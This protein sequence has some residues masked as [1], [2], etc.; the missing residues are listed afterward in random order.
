MSYEVR[1]QVIS[2]ILDNRNRNIGIVMHNSPD[3]DCIGSAVALENCLLK[4]NK[5]VDLIIQNR[6]PIEYSK[7][8]GENRVN[9]IFIPQN[10]YYD[11][12]FLV[13]CADPE[14]TIDNV[15]NMARCLITI[16]HHYG[17]KPFGD[18]YLYEHEAATGIIIYKIIK[19]LSP[20]DADI[21]NALYLT[22]RSDTNSFK[23]NNTDSKA[24]E[25]ASELLFKG[26]NLQLINDIYDNKTLSLLRLMGYSFA[27]IYY[28]RQYKIVYLIIRM[29][30]IKKAQSN[31]EEASMLIDYIRGINDVEIA[32]L[33]LESSD[34]NVRIKARS[35]SVNV[36][37]IMS[38]FDGGGHPTAA[39]TMIYCDDIYKVVENVILCAKKYIDKINKERS[40]KNDKTVANPDKR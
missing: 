1:K 21:A 27:N 12:V 23:N 25:I 6:I 20:I 7:I 5:H 32:F 10:K 39:G 30:Q 28:D 40:E 15:S 4:L 18:I 26:A 13:D 34:D 17:V 3:G 31:Y 24:H 9:K 14:R 16:D 19:S 35:K 33:F 29:D 22:I 2:K 8:I 37:E 11:V 36:S 38:Q